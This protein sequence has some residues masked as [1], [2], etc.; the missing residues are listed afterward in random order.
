MKPKVAIVG[1]GNVGS[2]LGAALLANGFPIKYGVR[3]PSA[4]KHK[5]LLKHQLGA[6]LGTVP[7]AVAWADAVLLA[8]PGEFEDAE[9]VAA[10]AALGP[11]ASKKIIIDATNPLCPYPGLESRLWTRG[12]VSGGE[13]L[14]AALPDAAVYKAFNTVGA[15]QMGAADGRLIP[16]GSPGGALTMLFCGPGSPKERGVVETIIAGVGFAPRYV[17]PIRYA[18]NLE[19]IAELWVHLG[20]PG[21]GVGEARDLSWGRNFHFQALGGGGSGGA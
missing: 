8:V 20:V 15:E 14:A 17:G 1:A 21:V 4:A 5:K 3:D 19:A 9:I 16:G 18:R 12:G 2:V 10:A 7:D 13:V 11:A 6:T